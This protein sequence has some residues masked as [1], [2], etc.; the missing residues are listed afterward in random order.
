MSL[1]ITEEIWPLK[2]RFESFVTP[3]SLTEV[4]GTRSLPRKSTVMFLASPQSGKH[5]FFKD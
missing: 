4:T 2:V 5:G 3:R 1:V